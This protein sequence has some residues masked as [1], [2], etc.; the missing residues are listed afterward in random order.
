MSKQTFP[1]VELHIF[2]DNDNN[3]VEVDGYIHESDS[4]E[5]DNY[6]KSFQTLDAAYKW[7]KSLNMPVKENQEMM[8]GV[9][10]QKYERFEE[11]NGT[12]SV[13]LYKKA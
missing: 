13:V 10:L 3:V 11:T 1:Y 12:E 8:P 2:Y 6:V 7:Q 4:H 5:Y 9:D